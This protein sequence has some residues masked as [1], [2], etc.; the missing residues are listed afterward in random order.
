M[1]VTHRMN[2]VSDA[3]SLADVLRL[4]PVLSNL[5]HELQKE[6]GMS[7]GFISSKGQKFA[8]DIP[9]QRGATDARRDALMSILADFRA[10]DHGQSIKTKIDKVK[11]SLDRMAN[12]RK[13]VDTA[14]L[15]VGEMAKY[16]SG[17]IQNLLTNVEEMVALSPNATVIRG[18][19]AY[20]AF[21]QAKERAGIERAMGAAGFSA[22]K[23]SPAVFQ[24]FLSLIAAQ[25]T[26]LSTF[27]VF[28]TD[29][30]REFLAKTVSGP[31]TAEVDR[32]RKIAIDSDETGNTGGIE[33]GAW[34]DAITKKINLLK[35]VEDRLA[36]DLVAAVTDIRTQ[37]QSEEIGLLVGLAI[38][39]V[40]L[41]ALSALIVRS[42]TQPVTS[43]TRQMGALAGGDLEI[44]INGVVRKDE[45]GDMG[46]AVLV[47][48]ENAMAV[49]RMEAEQA[50]AKERAEQE[51]RTAMNLLADEF[52]AS[53]GGV[54]DTVSSASAH[55]NS[56]ATQ[57]AGNAQQTSEQSAVVASASE[58]ASA[59][60]QTVSAAAEELSK[61]IQEITRQ[62]TESTRIASDAVHQAQSANAKISGLVESAQ[63]VGEVVNLITDIAE[64]TNLLALNATIEAARA[65]DAGKG[66]AVVASEVK[67]LANQT[68]KA[69]E[70]IAR[71]IADIQAST[72]DAVT[73]IGSVT[74]VIEQINEIAGNIASAVEEQGAATQEIARNVEQ[75]ASGTSAVN[76]NIQHVSLAA[77]Q[78]GKSAD[79]IL[80]AANE[81]S[82]QSGVLKSVVAEFLDKVRAA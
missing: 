3:E 25:E 70:E 23:F 29:G 26:Y 39:L 13:G 27:A 66:F 57:L 22:G 54:V 71:Q 55:L 74:A 72:N 31:I 50:A 43:L 75:A 17:T 20:T 2:Q 8:A 61:S 28:A 6:R 68:A 52:S 12:V 63:K 79:G 16:Y 15:S 5:V 67:N 21:L 1:L 62:V 48:K 40:L 60:T 37:A 24:R 19:G 44:E 77:D 82:N 36:S 7:A 45:I 76:E 69:T 49:K 81:L 32:L 35:Q 73:V 30:Q 59:N 18:I 42:I 34:F 64:Q 10:E 4:A 47:F 78:T 33:A 14:A 46:R 58:Q 65:G 41:A 53:V 38:G 56:S 9:V 80:Q 11:E 51:K